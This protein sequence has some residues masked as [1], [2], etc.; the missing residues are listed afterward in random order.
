MPACSGTDAGHIAARVDSVSIIESVVF[1][2]CR[3]L[4][5]TNVLSVSVRCQ[6]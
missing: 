1:M 3:F 5:Q 6:H 2:A 4:S